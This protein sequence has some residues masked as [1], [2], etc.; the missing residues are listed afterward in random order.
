VGELFIP[1]YGTMHRLHYAGPGEHYHSLQARESDDEMKRYPANSA[2]VAQKM[3]GPQQSRRVHMTTSQTMSWPQKKDS[4]ENMQYEY[5]ENW[6]DKITCRTRSER[7][8]SVRSGG[9]DGSCELDKKKNIM[10]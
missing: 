6:Y 4:L 7:R 5:G 10:A 9:T 3:K 1:L 8:S 2:E